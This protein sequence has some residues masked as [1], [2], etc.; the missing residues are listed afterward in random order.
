[1]EAEN[2]NGDR[3]TFSESRTVN[4]GDYESNQHFFSFSTTVS[5]RYGAKKNVTIRE[6]STSNLLRTSPANFKKVADKMVRQ[7]RTV[8]DYQELELR[9]IAVAK[10]FNDDDGM[11][12]KLAYL[13]RKLRDGKMGR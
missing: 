12:Q 2:S 7:V 4:M 6:T 1:M 9:T 11:K 13:K 5:E 3:L 10:G 8:L